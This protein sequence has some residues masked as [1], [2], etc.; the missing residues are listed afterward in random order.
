MMNIYIAEIVAVASTKDDRVQVRVLPQMRDLSKDYLPVW[1]SFFKNSIITGNVG[2]LVWVVANE[3]FTIGYIL[4]YANMYTDSSNYEEGTIPPKLFD[5]ISNLHVSLKG[6][7][8]N[9]RDII[10]THYNEIS[11]SFF[12]RKDGATITAFTNGTLSVVRPNEITFV[13]GSSIL[14]I[15]DGEIALNAKNL[16]LGGKSVQLGD[17]PS[18]NVLVTDGGS[19]AQTARTSSKVFA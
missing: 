10:V 3:E 14:S 12:Q 7:L 5:K 6:T 9:Y 18:G 1:P 2:D 4:G 13:V 17:C 16:K 15:K 8:L 19:S 11:I